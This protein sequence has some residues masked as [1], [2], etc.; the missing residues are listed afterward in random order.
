MSDIEAECINPILFQIENVVGDNSCFYRAFSNILNYEMSD[1]SSNIYRNKKDLSQIYNHNLWGFC[2]ENQELL[3]KIIQNKSYQWIINNKDSL[4]DDLQ[5]SISDLVEST[6][7]IPFE[8]YEK[9]YKFYAGDTIIRQVTNS[10]SKEVISSSIVKERWGG[11]IEQY[12]LSKIYNC[13][14]NIYSALWF[15]DKTCQYH[16][17]KI[18]KNNKPYKD[19]VLKLYQTIGKGEHVYN[20]LWKNTKFGGHYMAMYEN[21]I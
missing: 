4:H 10:D 18:S 13:T 1:I 20:L 8:E 7:G 6:H 19:V 21:N 5:M 11:F 15:D 9:I 3:S 14:I 2:G 12:A 16:S 17:G